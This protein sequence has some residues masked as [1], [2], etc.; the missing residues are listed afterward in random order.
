M[1]STVFEPGDMQTLIALGTIRTFPKN[2]MLLQ[3][4]DTSDQLYVV[5]SG[6]LK[7]F[8]ADA[9][10]KEVIIDSLGPQ[11]FFGEMALD[12]EPRS[13]SVMTTE[14]SSLCI[15]QHEQFKRF[16][17]DNPAGALSLIVALIRRARHLTRTVGNLALLDVYGRVAHLL[18][19]SAVEENG[20]LVVTEKISQV[21]IAKKVGA[22]R[23][24]VSRILG[25]LKEGGYISMDNN[26]M[27][28]RQALPKR[29]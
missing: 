2:T 15:I 5:M 14:T 1:T 21:E 9:D 13:A 24:M 29:W 4:G 25:D 7:V 22:S 19:E 26:R 11:Q 18:I 16:L 17:A 8:L 6:R 27:V 23:E 12:A 20:Q 10:G 28:I 3:E